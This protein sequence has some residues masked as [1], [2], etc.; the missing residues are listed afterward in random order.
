MSLTETTAAGVVLLRLPAQLR[1][2]VQLFDILAYARR[3][4]DDLALWCVEQA[5]SSVSNFGFK[6]FDPVDVTAGVADISALL[7]DATAPLISE[8]FPYAAVRLSDMADADP[9]AAWLDTPSELREERGGA[10]VYYS[11]DGTDLK[12]RGRDGSLTSVDG[13]TATINCACSRAVADIPRNLEEK[14]LELLL[15]RVVAAHAAGFIQRAM[16]Q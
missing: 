7:S 11:L 15:G 10:F 4:C 8:G 1:G 6:T 5:P 9:D 2:R 12:F 13:V 3:A 16:P 14:Y